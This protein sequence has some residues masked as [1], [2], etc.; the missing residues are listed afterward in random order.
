VKVIGRKTRSLD[1]WKKAA[2][3]A[4]ARAMEQQLARPENIDKGAWEDGNVSALMNEVWYHA[5]KLFKSTEALASW[6]GFGRDPSTG[7][8]LKRALLEFAADVANCAMIVAEVTGALEHSEDDAVGES[9]E[10]TIDWHVSG[11]YG[12]GSP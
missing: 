1:P 10:T 12:G 5:A 9:G 8:D 4:F 2:V 3:A 11:H 6:D 7:E